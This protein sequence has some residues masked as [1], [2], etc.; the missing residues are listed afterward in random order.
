MSFLE[1]LALLACLLMLTLVSVSF[2]EE[3]EATNPVQMG[4]K[5]TTFILTNQGDSS[6]AGIQRFIAGLK[7]RGY[8]GQTGLTFILHADKATLDLPG[9]RAF[10]QPGPRRYVMAIVDFGLHMAGQSYEFSFRYFKGA[11]D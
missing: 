6:F 4:P 7:E 2:A 11:P 8:Y 9:Q 3:V 1:T 10:W 5:F